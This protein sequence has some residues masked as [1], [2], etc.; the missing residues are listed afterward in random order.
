MSGSM[1][2]GISFSCERATS[3]NSKADILLVQ[4]SPLWTSRHFLWVLRSLFLLKLM[5]QWI[6]L[7]AM[8]CDL[9]GLTHNK[10][11][12]RCSILKYEPSVASP[13]FVI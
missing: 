13:A 2:V 6:S 7:H 5:Q 10:Y 1:S 11:F 3:S 8:A 4:S 12:A 9:L